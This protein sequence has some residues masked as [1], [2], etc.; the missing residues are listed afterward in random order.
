MQ[1]PIPCL[2]QLV[3]FFEVIFVLENVLVKTLHSNVSYIHTAFFSLL[4]NKK[5][6]RTKY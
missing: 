5:N 6:A 3:Y 1:I 2:S 4:L